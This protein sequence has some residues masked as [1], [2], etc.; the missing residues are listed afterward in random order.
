[1]L[2][3]A[4]GLAYASNMLQVS[5]NICI[6]ADEVEF[7]FVKS[8]GPGGQHV[9]KVA[10]AVQLRFDVENSR[11]LPDEVRKRLYRFAGNRINTSGTL[12]IDARRFKSRER[13]RRDAEQR[14][15][16]LVQMAALRP[17]TRMP[18]K[19]SAAQK[20][21]R[22]EDKRSRGF[23]KQLRGRVEDTGE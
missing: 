8:S 15:V 3:T 16:E 1:M 19:P 9:N 22:L 7:K 14:L 12:V 6:Q 4:R 10:T 23:T 21:R 17:K 11:S 18:T 20:K 13:N 5:R 2:V